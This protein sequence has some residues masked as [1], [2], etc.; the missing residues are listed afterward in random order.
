MKAQFGLAI[1]CIA[2]PPLLLL[3]M[4]KF[5]VVVDDDGSP[6]TR[7]AD[8]NFQLSI[9]PVKTVAAGQPPPQ[10]L[11]LDELLTEL[12]LTDFSDRLVQ[13]CPTPSSCA[14]SVRSR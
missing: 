12:G 8:R 7:A 3:M 6:T 14:I 11:Q 5:L 10:G 13:V 2:L 9:G 1:I 4:C